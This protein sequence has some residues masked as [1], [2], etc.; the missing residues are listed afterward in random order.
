FTA[1]Q[2][3]DLV[4]A[5]EE[6]IREAVPAARLIFIEPD[7]RREAIASAPERG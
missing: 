6:R 4:D 2:V 5:A 7:V 1:Q 3:A